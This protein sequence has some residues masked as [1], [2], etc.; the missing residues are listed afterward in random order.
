MRSVPRVRDFIEGV[1]D[2]YF[3]GRCWLTFHVRGEVAGVVLWGAPRH[4][5]IEPLTEALP[6][7][8]SPLAQRLG[9]LVDI[10]RLT[11]VDQ[12][13]V[14]ALVEYFS[15]HS[16]RI[17]EIASRAAIVHGGGLGL[18]LATGLPSLTPL[19]YDV[20]MFAETP[21]ALVWLGCRSS[22]R[23]AAELD[24]AQAASVGVMPLVRDLRAYCIANARAVAL[25]SAAAALGLSPRS[26][27]RKL[28]DEGT[29]L[30]REL[31]AARVE[32][33]KTLLVETDAAI[34]VIAANVG[35]SSAQH[36]GLLF[37]RATGRTPRQWRAAPTS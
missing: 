10:T 2:S 20:G 28:R 30:Q 3:V 5:D 34:D 27:Q 18:A 16:K 11:N 31:N 17:G 32:A 23:I 26:L 35:C 13:V 12:G 29:S 21:E 6:L 15:S 33:A 14:A 4:T 36:L 7:Y 24:E 19:P 9:R 37:R 8:G 1:H 25:P 22:A